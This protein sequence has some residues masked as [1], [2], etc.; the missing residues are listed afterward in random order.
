MFQA[1]SLKSLITYQTK[2]YLIDSCQEHNHFTPPCTKLHPLTFWLLLSDVT[3][4]PLPHFPTFNCSYL[5]LNPNQ[6]FNFPHCQPREKRNLLTSPHKVY[7]M[8]SSKTSGE[9]KRK[10][11]KIACSK[12]AIA[13]DV[14]QRD[15]SLSSRWQVSYRKQ[16][17][18][19]QHVLKKCQWLS[20][21]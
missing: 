6:L 3:L 7:C 16:L 17:V 5:R 12:P 4:S 14:Y 15:H 18:L 19:W 1:L 9:K 8:K 13:R 2:C 21:W 10:R 11:G 20:L